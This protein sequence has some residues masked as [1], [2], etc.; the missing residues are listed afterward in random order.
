MSVHEM[1]GYEPEPER[2]GVSSSIDELLENSAAYAAEF[3]GPS[4]HVP[5]KAVA[6]VTCMD[7]RINGFR[8]FGL[9][10]G[11]AHVLRNAGGLVT[12][13]V[14]RSLVISQRLLGTRE[15][16]LVHHTKCGLHRAD[17]A[18]LWAEIA[19]DV[20]RPPPYELGAF[21]DLDDAVRAEPSV[22]SR[23]GTASVASCTTSIPA[24]CAKWSSNRG[25]RAASLKAR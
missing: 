21:D 18:T 1:S 25:L 13:D 4:T 8:I 23:T 15:V 14:L 12:D 20:G 11:D 19:G 2:P 7:T 6:I 17:D 5:S 16:M 24:A 10:P 3:A 9:E 22:S